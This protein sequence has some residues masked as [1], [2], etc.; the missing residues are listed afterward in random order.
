MA[1]ARKRSPH[2]TAIVAEI[3]EI[4]A[5]IK[6]EREATEGASW[7][8]MLQSEFPLA[9]REAGMLTDPFGFAEGNRKRFFIA[10]FM[11]FL[12]QWS[13]QNSISYYAPT[14]FK[15]IGLKGTTTGLFASGIYGIVKIVATSIFVFLGIERIGRSK[16]LGFGGA[17]MSLFL[18]VCSILE[19]ETLRT[20]CSLSKTFSDYWSRLLHPHSRP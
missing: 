14:I 18:W 1:W 9:K 11:F 15:S 2:D 6:E 17:G 3:A 5:A 4:T 8:E 19:C 13:G 20:V 7:R 12:Q 16:S 10:F